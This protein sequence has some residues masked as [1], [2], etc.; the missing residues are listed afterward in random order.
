M[1]ERRHLPAHELTLRNYRH[2]GVNA[3]DSVCKQMPCFYRL[4]PKLLSYTLLWTQ[5]SAI[6]SVMSPRLR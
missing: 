1:W 5:R 6:W 3:Q 4:L 2:V